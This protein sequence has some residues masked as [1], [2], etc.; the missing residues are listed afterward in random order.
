[1]RQFSHHD[2]QQRLTQFRRKLRERVLHFICEI[3][4]GWIRRLHRHFQRTFPDE[5]QP[6]ASTSPTIDHPSPQD[7]CQPRP[8]TAPACKTF[9]AFPRTAQSLLY[10]ILGIVRIAH[11]SVSDSIQCRGVF[12]NQDD[13]VVIEFKRTFMVYKRGKVPK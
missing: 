8:L 12:V 10:D 1:M 13:K 5:H 7:R 3:V 2:Q 6:P 11:Q 4:R 9:S